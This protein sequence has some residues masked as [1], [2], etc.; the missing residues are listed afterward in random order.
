MMTSKSGNKSQMTWTACLTKSVVSSDYKIISKIKNT[1]VE[2]PKYKII[3]MV[4]Q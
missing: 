1:F 2:G 3:L 4:L